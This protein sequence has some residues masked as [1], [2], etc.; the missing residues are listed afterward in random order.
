ML[1]WK[2]ATDGIEKTPPKFAIANGFV[3]GSFLQQTKFINKEGE[4]VTRK[5]D[6]YELTDTLKAMIPPLRPYGCVFAYSGGAQKSLRE[7]YQ[8]FDMDQN[9]LGGVMNQLNQAGIGEHIYFVLCGR[10]T[11]DQKQTV[12]KRSKV[13]TQ[14]YIDILTWFVKESGHSGYLNT[15]VPKECPQSILIEDTSTRNNIYNSAN[16]TVEANYEGGT[17]YFSTA[18]DPSQN[19]SLYGSSDKFALTMFQHSA[20]TLLAYGKR[21]A[22]NADMIIENVLPFAFS[23]VIG[24]PQMKQRV[25]VSLEVYIQ[26]YAAFLDTIYERANYYSH[27]SHLQQA[28]IV[29]EWGNDM[30]VKC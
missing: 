16:K 13:D 23:F 3:I 1:H 29:Q 6:D 18:Q 5:G 7:N 22:K 24:G 2:A 28:N 14:L 8:F 12:H 30:Q 27:E 26:V 25:K 21:Y 10:M 17:Y 15:S 19:T 20:P 4:K 9:R 11:P